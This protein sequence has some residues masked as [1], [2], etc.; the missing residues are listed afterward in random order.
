MSDEVREQQAR[1]WARQQ[2]EAATPEDDI[3]EELSRRGFSDPWIDAVMAEPLPEREEGRPPRAPGGGC[4]AGVVF[5]IVLALGCLGMIVVAVLV[6]MG[7][8]VPVFV[9]AREKAGTTSC[10]ANLKQLTTAQLMYASDW[11]QVLPDAS[12][13]TDAQMPYLKNESIYLCPEDP[14]PFM[15]GT[16]PVSY[17]MNVALSGQDLRKLPNPAL[18]PSLYDATAP[19]GDHTIGAFRHNDGVNVGFVDGHVKWV[20]RSGWGAIWSAGPSGGAAGGSGAPLSPPPAATPPPPSAADERQQAVEP[21]PQDITEA[22]VR[23]RES[24]RLSACTSNLKQ[25]A[26]AQLM[27]AQDWDERMQPAASWPQQTQPYV[28][29]RE[30]F[31]CPADRPGS[32]QTPWP[33]SYGMNEA[34]S[35]Q[36]LGSV[37]AP[38]EVPSLMDATAIAGDPARM[39]D[40]RHEGGAV[41]SF[42]DGHVRALTESDWRARWPAQAG[43][44]GEGE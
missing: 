7:I 30:L 19:S 14:S 34:L 2:R 38:A 13:W 21:A 26:L 17:G 9:R 37:A 27:Y 25:L 44:A 12:T 41:V 10:M 39:V 43:E 24:A 33:L 16:W 20:G 32:M 28:R 1:V 31:I 11:D 15:P 4:G 5:W 22:H 3:R 8:T 35:G 18:S 29:N 36:Q 42:V 6:V 23:A 40:F